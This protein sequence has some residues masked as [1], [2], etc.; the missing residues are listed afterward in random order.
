MSQQIPQNLILTPV[1]NTRILSA[2]LVGMTGPGGLGSCAR[3]DFLGF[4][5]VSPPNVLLTSSS[6]HFIASPIWIT[7]TAIGICTNK[8]SEPATVQ[9]LNV[10]LLIHGVLAATFSAK[11][12][13]EMSVTYFD[14]EKSLLES[15][16]QEGERK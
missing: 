15:L 10:Q 16:T 4:S 11:T 3:V 9:S 2:F 7:P 1:G 6:V 5:F 12:A 13:L 8:V 14:D